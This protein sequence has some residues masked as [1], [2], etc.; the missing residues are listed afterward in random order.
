MWVIKND[1]GGVVRYVGNVGDALLQY[2]LVK[3]SDKRVLR[4][5]NQSVCSLTL[6][7]IRKQFGSQRFDMAWEDGPI[8]AATPKNA[9][10][11]YIVLDR[12]LRSVAV[13]YSSDRRKAVYDW[14]ISGL[15]GTQGAERDHYVSCLLQLEDGKTE[16]YYD[17]D[18]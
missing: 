12:R 9:M 3:P 1:S 13:L 6:Q 8:S 16:L 11:K 7:S 17:L 5:G 18:A 2:G 14:I 4:F 15:R 10:P